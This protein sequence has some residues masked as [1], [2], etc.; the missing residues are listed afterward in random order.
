MYTLFVVDVIVAKRVSYLSPQANRDSVMGSLLCGFTT[1]Q[2]LAFDYLT[3][4]L[5]AGSVGAAGSSSG[6]I[7]HVALLFLTG[8]ISLAADIGGFMYASRRIAEF[9]TAEEKRKSLG[10]CGQYECGRCVCALFGMFT[11]QAVKAKSPR[12]GDE[13]AEA[14]G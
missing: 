9:P 4:P 6:L 3:P 2:L 5:C 11:R 13:E 8:I 1:A 14:G 10:A 7:Q 12:D